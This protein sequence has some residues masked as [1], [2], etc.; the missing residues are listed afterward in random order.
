MLVL[1][2]EVLEMAMEDAVGGGLRVW[3]EERRSTTE[4]R[5]GKEG[6]KKEGGFFYF[7]ALLFLYVTFLSG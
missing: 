4:G 7:I 5:E 6:R 2:L 1:V 3:V